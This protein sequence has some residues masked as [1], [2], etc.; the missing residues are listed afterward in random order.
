MV[1]Y[2]LLTVS[3]KS[4]PLSTLSFH[5]SE[6]CC[7]LF[8]L[9]QKFN[10]SNS[11]CALSTNVN[12]FI[13]LYN[14]KFTYIIDSPPCLVCKKK[15]ENEEGGRQPSRGRREVQRAAKPGITHPVVACKAHSRKHNGVTA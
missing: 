1:F 9:N 14:F 8:I 11:Y 15:N 13:I 3:L 4:I 12:V 2:K 10:C 7:P 5:S 6:P